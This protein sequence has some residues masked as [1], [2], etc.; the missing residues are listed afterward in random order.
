[1]FGILAPHYDMNNPSDS[2]SFLGVHPIFFL[3]LALLITFFLFIIVWFKTDEK[4]GDTPF[5]DLLARIPG[6]SIAKR[7]D[8][9]YE[10]VV[11]DFLGMFLFLFLWL[12]LVFKAESIA[13]FL[14]PVLAILMGSWMVRTY[15]IIREVRRCSLEQK[16]EQLTGQYLQM[17][18]AHGYHVYHDIILQDFN[19]DHVVVGPNGI[20]A[21]ETRTRRKLKKWGPERSV[22]VYD[23]NGITFP[24]KKPVRDIITL[25]EEH[26]MGL[27]KWLNSQINESFRVVPV[28]SLPGWDVEKRMR[29]NP[30]VLNP[31]QI[32][33]F[34]VNYGVQCL[35]NEEIQKITQ[36]LK[37]KSR[38]VTILENASEVKR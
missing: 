20:F 34:I 26:A 32:N 9:H 6:Q 30:P 38:Q 15:S 10:K 13:S 33:E 16:G 8:L 35:W 28:L 7:M 1:M 18:V 17:L 36:Q 12:L 25:A 23:R 29:E 14:S 5:R 2:F 19:V 22:V 3:P 4:R 21:V 31:K 27:Q 11:L 37:E 24:G